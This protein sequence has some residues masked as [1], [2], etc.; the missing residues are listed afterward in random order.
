VGVRGGGGGGGW[1]GR[2]EGSG[3]VLLAPPPRPRGGGALHIPAEGRSTLVPAR[4]EDGGCSREARGNLM[5]N[6]AVEG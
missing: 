6:D 5:R 3:V 4:G 1:G 2:R